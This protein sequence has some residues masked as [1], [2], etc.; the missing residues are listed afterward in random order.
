MTQHPLPSFALRWSAASALVAS[1]LLLAGCASTP[2]APQPPLQVRLLALNDFHGNLKPPPGGFVDPV[3]RTPTP[4]GGAAHLATALAEARAG[5]VHTAFVAAG[6]LIGATP[7]LSALL[8]D[9]PTIEVLSRMGLDFSAMGNHELDKGSAALLRLQG[10]GCDAKTGCQGPQPYKGAGFQYLAANTVVAATGRTLLPPYAIKRFDGV[11]VAFIGLTLKDTPSVVTPFGVAGLRFEDEADTV[12]RLVPELRKQGVEAIVVLMH[13]GGAGGGGIDECP[14]ASGTM[15]KLVP[16]FDKAVD[17]VISGHTHRAF[18]CRIDGRLVTSAGQYGTLLTTID[19][20]I[21]RASRK[22]VQAVA[23]NE[24]VSHE[25]FKADPAIAAQIA[26]YERIVAPL[27]KR[28]MGKLTVALT[29]N[30]ERNGESAMGRVIADAQLQATRDAG[31]QVALMNIGGVRSGLGADG[32]LDMVYEDLFS[33]QPFYN[34]LVTLTLSGAQ[35]L[36]LLEQQWQ[37]GRSRPLQI[38][39]TLRY[40]WD[41]RLPE[42]TRVLPGSVT[43]EGKPL[44]AAADYRVTV[45]AFLAD[46]GDAFAVLRQGRDKRPGLVDIDALEAYFKARSVFTPEAA[47]RA[48]RVD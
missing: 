36:Q 37:D 43:V 17:V 3:R 33:V 31:A 46:G 35:L 21:D 39:N 25:R 9:E 2:S 26:T 18:N 5:Q 8:H 38:S 7:L 4:A 14:N 11:A 23:K 12:N 45:N 27:A 30:V 16:R 10:G 6:D 44:N 34:Q 24:V 15:L 13:E 40:Q 28:P 48:V 42:G 32:R 19:L 29:R 22:V 20:S 47:P 41:G 1:A